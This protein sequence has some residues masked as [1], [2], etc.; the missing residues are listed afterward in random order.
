M[1][2]FTGPGKVKD[3]LDMPPF[4]RSGITASLYNFDIDDATVKLE[5]ALW[6]EIH[7]LPVLSASRGTHVSLKGLAS[8]SGSQSHN[9]QLSEKRVKAVRSFLLGHGVSEAQVNFNSRGEDEAAF[10]GVKD[11]TESEE[12]R[13]VTVQLDPPPRLSRARFDRLNPMNRRDGFDDTGFFSWLSV[14]SFGLPKTIRL[15]N[16][17]G[18]TVSTNNA[19]VARPLSPL[20]N[21]P[22]EEIIV[23]S[24][25]ELIRIEGGVPGDTRLVV[26]ELNGRVMAE[27][28]VTSLAHKEVQVAFHFVQDSTQ[29][30]TRPEAD[31]D[32]M[33]AIVN[34]V[35]EP[36]ANITF[37]KKSVAPMRFTT[38]LG[39]PAQNGATSLVTLGNKFQTLAARGDVKA[40]INV[41]FVWEFQ[42]ISTRDTDAR[43]DEIGGKHVVFED[44]AGT[45]TGL[46]LGHEYGHCL[47]LNHRDSAQELLMWDTTDDRGGRLLKDE[48]LT[49][50]SKV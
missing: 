28:D 35:Y 3:D 27:L 7:A 5:H 32:Q 45:D 17:E 19:A 29:R 36:Q 49:A 26:R 20:T 44:D 1:R 14:P 50:H 9:Q 2:K 46:S 4:A 23:G 13:A 18:M 24:N 41:Y 15:R 16:A 48:I 34:R 12:W 10:F 38:S 39:D 40:R 11:G 42:R 25:N 47:G 43:V 21:A 30:A 31:I 33:M 6:L 8:R 37:K 22:V